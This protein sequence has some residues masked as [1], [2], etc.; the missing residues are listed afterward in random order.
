M[1][2]PLVKMVQ[3]DFRWTAQYKYSNTLLLKSRIEISHF[4]RGDEVDIIPAYGYWISQDVILKVPKAKLSFSLRYAIFDCDSY[5]TRMYCYEDDLPN[6]FS[7]P[8]FYGPGSRSYLMV[9]YKVNKNT[10]I[11]FRYAQT[12]YYNV[13]AFGTGLDLIKGNTKTDVSAEL[14][15]SI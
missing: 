4:A 15:I 13:I 9:K 14:R 8:S 5:Y 6:S 11:W 12:Y 3:D 10:D 1:I 2:T 7:I